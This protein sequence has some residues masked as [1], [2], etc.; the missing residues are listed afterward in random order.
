MI[1]QLLLHFPVNDSVPLAW[2]TAD[3]T[4]ISTIDYNNMCI[5]RVYQNNPKIRRLQQKQRVHPASLAY[6]RW[7]T[8][9][10]PFDLKLPR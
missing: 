1:K 5:C 8:H 3:Y 7:N 6:Q 10:S 4:N 2:P 9:L